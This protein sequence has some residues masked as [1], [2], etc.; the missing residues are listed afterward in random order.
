[1]LMAS[2]LAACAHDKPAPVPEV[3][4]I[5]RAVEIAMKPL[6][7]PSLPGDCAVTERSGVAEGDRLDIALVKTD[8]ALLRANQRVSRCHAH[9]EKI[10]K[11]ARSP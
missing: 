2:F 4:Y 9:H 11:S 8:H 7:I 6:E 10:R 1:M 3:V 5:D